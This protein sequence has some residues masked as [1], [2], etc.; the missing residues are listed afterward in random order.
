VSSERR[1]EG[2]V[3]LVTG[4]SSGNGL[5]IARRYALEGAAVVVADL[6]E[7]EPSD[8]EGTDYV[9]CDVTSGDD[10]RAA[11]ATA[12]ERFGRLDVAVANAG[13]NLGVYELVEEPLSVWEGT[14]AVNQTGVWWTCREAALVMADGGRLIVVA[15]VASLVGAP[16]GVAYNASKGAVLQLVRTLAPQ[17]APRRITVNAICPGFIRTAMTAET[18][19]DPDKRAR[20]LAAHPLGRLGEPEDVA[21]AAFYLASDDASWITGSALVVDGGYTCV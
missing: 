16:S 21:G 1:L 4:G 8:R 7:P 3:A 6:A 13:V 20:A 9:R 15:S 2:R 10:V 14:I 19:S 5:A 11:V 12:V 18:Q 17:L